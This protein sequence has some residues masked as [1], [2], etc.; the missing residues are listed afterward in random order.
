MRQTRLPLG[1]S[2][3]KLG[4]LNPSLGDCATSLVKVWAGF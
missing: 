1:L 4:L 2:F 3:M